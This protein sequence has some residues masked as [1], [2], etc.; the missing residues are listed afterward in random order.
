VQL[1]ATQKIAEAHPL[2]EKK[3]KGKIIDAWVER[4]AK[5]ESLHSHPSTILAAGRDVC[6]N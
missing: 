4:V 6:D 3:L 2:R 5:N 1:L